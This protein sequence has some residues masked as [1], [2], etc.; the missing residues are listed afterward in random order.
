GLLLAGRPRSRDLADLAG[1]GSSEP[2]DEARDRGHRDRGARERRARAG[3]AVRR[4]PAGGPRAGGGAGG[5]GPRAHDEGAGADRGGAAAAVTFRY[6]LR[7]SCDPTPFTL[8]LGGP[9]MWFG[10]T[11]AWAASD[12]CASWA[13]SLCPGGGSA[14]SI[15]SAVP[16]PAPGC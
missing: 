16:A 4:D 15:A 5:R 1:A 10:W 3:G 7:F 13:A 11:T 14:C 12:P 2:R 8:T 9:M 6:A